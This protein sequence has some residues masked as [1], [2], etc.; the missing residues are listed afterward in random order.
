MHHHEVKHLMPHE[1]NEQWSPRKSY[2]N[3]QTHTTLNF[4]KKLTKN[5]ITV[6][7]IIKLKNL[8]TVWA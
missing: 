3:T 7:I 8:K 5:K 4:T 1:E 2:N 6:R